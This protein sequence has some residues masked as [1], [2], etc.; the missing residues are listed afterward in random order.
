MIILRLNLS[1][2]WVGL[3]KG[4]YTKMTF[5]VMIDK[6]TKAIDDKDHVK[7]L[8]LELNRA[9]DKLWSYYELA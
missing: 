9:Y 5:P 8:L 2:N 7:R 1:K 3:K 6:I 4:F